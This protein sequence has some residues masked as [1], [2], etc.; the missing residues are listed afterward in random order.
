MRDAAGVIAVEMRGQQRIDTRNLRY[1]RDLGNPPRVAPHVLVR[2]RRVEAGK[3]DV[4][5]ER[6]AGGGYEQSGLPAFGV[7]EI[8]VER[9]VRRADGGTH[10]HDQEQR[11]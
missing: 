9:L 2:I 3:A 4:D 11:A 8:D 10:Q 7:D 1:L 5:H 6:L